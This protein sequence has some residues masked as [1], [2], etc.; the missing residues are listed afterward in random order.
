MAYMVLKHTNPVLERA[1]LWYVA[2][3]DHPEHHGAIVKKPI[4]EALDFCARM[5][6]GERFSSCDGG[7]TYE[8]GMLRQY[9]NALDLVRRMGSRAVDFPA[10]K[11]L[12]EAVEMCAGT[13]WDS[14]I[15][16]QANRSKRALDLGV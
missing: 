5:N 1:D 10:G 2:D 12:R 8:E 4:R 3:M 7:E 6:R 13:D 14:W 9:Q 15:N 16:T 11:Y